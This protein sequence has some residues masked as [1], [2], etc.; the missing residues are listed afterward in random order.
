MGNLD[1]L[2]EKYLKHPYWIFDKDFEKQ[3]YAKFNVKATIAN[4]A[5]KAIGMGLVNAFPIAAINSALVYGVNRLIDYAED[6]QSEYIVR[7]YLVVTLNFELNDSKNDVVSIIEKVGFDLLGMSTLRYL[8]KA[9]DIK[10]TYNEYITGKVKNRILAYMFNASMIFDLW[11]NENFKNVWD[12]YTS[13]QGLSGLKNIE[14][15]SKTKHIIE[16]TKCLTDYE[17][18][19]FKEMLNYRSKFIDS[20]RDEYTLLDKEISYII[21][22]DLH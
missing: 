12:N 1:E 2:Y 14:A 22:K 13:F 9:E 18:G 11:N 7:L 21:V 4:T 19:R 15:P 5:R 8:E 20:I 6:K 16:R 10:S 17:F 3:L